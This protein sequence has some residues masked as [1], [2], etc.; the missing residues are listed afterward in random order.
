MRI[1]DKMQFN[2]VNQNL[3]KNRSDMSE[4]QNQAATQKRINKPS[5]DPLAAAR[6]LAART[7]E[8]GNQQFIKNIN[9]AKSFLEFTDQSLG[10]LSEIL[11][12]AK[13][14]AIS[15]SNDAS[16][17]EQSRQVTAS[18]IE[19]IY[20]QSVQIGNRKLGERYIFGGSQ[21][22]TAPFD[23]EGGYQ[24]NDS[25]MKI[26][27][28]KDTFVAMNIPG[29]K[30]FLGKGLSGDGIARSRYET[31]TTVEALQ[32]FKVEEIERRE[33]NKEFEENYV[34]TRAPASAYRAQRIGAPSKDP[35]NDSAGVN[36]FESL[37]GLEISLRTN[38]KAG[39]QE[40][41]DTLDQ[42][43]SQVVLARSEVGARVMAVNTTTDSLQKAIVD[44]KVTASQLEDVELFEVVSNMNKTDSALRA[45]LETSG[46]L[47]QPS[48]L[49][50]LK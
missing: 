50:F 37:R 8:R 18:E 22:Q 7:E 32:G 17:N 14:L 12:R 49:D 19:Q 43:I 9:N 25:D 48:L 36:L 20:N 34:E 42:A 39:I 27:I 47:I 21:T 5:D 1:A 16:G 38:D 6:V 3:T 2:Q 26:G 10:E 30:V 15:Q 33:Q 31:P 35:I 45:T 46:K 44:N 29:D 28:H 24:G 4:L 11:M 23:R 13:E 40:S 41:L